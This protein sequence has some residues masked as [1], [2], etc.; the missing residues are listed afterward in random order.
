MGIRGR[1]FAGFLRAIRVTERAIARSVDCECP[2]SDAT[3]DSPSVRTI[4]LRL[5]NSLPK[6]RCRSCHTV[7]GSELPMIA[8]TED[9]RSERAFTVNRAFTSTLVT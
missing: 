1:G 9:E 8:R 4:A 2:I 7:L 6:H 5:G 3:L